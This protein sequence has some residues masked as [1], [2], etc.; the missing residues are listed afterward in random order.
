[1]GYKFPDYFFVFF[2]RR[3]NALLESATGVDV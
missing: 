1:M 3:L 2:V